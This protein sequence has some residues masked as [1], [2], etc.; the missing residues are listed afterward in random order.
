MVK[1]VSEVLWM[2]LERLNIYDFNEEDI[3]WS[4]VFDFKW[5]I[6]VMNFGQIYVL[7][8]VCRIVVFDLVFGF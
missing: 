5:F 4:G 7:Y 8:I 3:V 6:E 1:N 2:V